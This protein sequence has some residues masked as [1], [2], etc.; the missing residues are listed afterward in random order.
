MEDTRT[1]TIYRYP[2]QKYFAAAEALD[3]RITY[4]VAEDETVTDC[5]REMWTDYLSVEH[6]KEFA[7][8]I[9]D[10]TFTVTA[11]D[12]PEDLRD[13]FVDLRKR[14]E[15]TPDQERGSWH[16]SIDAM[17]KMQA[18]NWV[19][20]Q[21]T[22]ATAITLKLDSEDATSKLGLFGEWFGS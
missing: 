9:I 8:T 19:W 22:L 17:T 14:I 16:A 12:L 13:L 1:V 10:F 15:T 11:E 18:F 20:D 2:A 4:L 7:K 3:K 5:D 21:A 6:A